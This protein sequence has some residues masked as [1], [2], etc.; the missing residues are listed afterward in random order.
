MNV[1]SRYF[2]N[3]LAKCE[4]MAVECTK[5]K[6][7]Y[8]HTTT[9]CN[10]PKMNRMYTKS[11]HVKNKANI[12]HYIHQYTR[13]TQ[14]TKLHHKTDEEKTSTKADKGKT[15]VIIDKNMLYKK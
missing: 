9:G 13:T 8:L 3:F 11:V 4:G 5:H 10:Y 7:L 1:F 15:I 2:L 6:F 14:K 12:K